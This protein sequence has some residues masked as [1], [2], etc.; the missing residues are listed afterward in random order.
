MTNMRRT[1]Y[2][3]L[4]TKFVEIAQEMTERFNID[5]GDLI[6]ILKD[7]VSV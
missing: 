2:D 4:E 5:M 1:K 6:D 7:G 3:I